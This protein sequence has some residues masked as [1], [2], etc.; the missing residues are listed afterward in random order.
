MLDQ[1]RH[2]SPLVE[3][4]GSHRAR[5]ANPSSSTPWT[6]S[7]SRCKL[8]RQQLKPHRP[9]FLPPRASLPHRPIYLQEFSS[10]GYHQ[11]KQTC[12]QNSFTSRQHIGL[13]SWLVPTWGWKPGMLIMTQEESLDKEKMASLDPSRMRREI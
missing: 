11:P 4:N 6:T 9:T 10:Q 7:T 2:L 1:V 8:P 3:L 5:E 12:T 13:T